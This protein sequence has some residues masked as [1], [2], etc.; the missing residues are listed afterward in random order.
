M[1]KIWKRQEKI[2]G[3]IANSWRSGPWVLRC[4]IIYVDGSCTWELTPDRPIIRDGHLATFL[5]AHETET[6]APPLNWA[7]TRISFND[8]EYEE[9]L[10]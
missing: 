3:E 4:R 9:H 2:P 10:N 8:W 7:S 5:G 6:I 1:M